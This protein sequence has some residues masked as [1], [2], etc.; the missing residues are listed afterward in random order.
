MIKEKV[1]SIRILPNNKFRLITSLGVEDFHAVHLCIGNLPYKDPYNLIDHPNFIFNPFPME[2]NMDSIP[3]GSRVGVLGTGLTSI[4]IFRY[5]EYNRPDLMLSFFSNSGR[6]K[7]IGGK[8]EHIEYKF[9]TKE[10]IKNRKENNKGFIPLETFINWFKK[11]IENQNLSLEMD[12]I[13]EPFGSK[14]NMEEDLKDLDKI[15]VL[16]SILLDLNPLLTDLWMA[17]TETDK[18][19]FLENYHGQWDKLRSSIPTESGRELILAWEKN[20]IKVFG[21]LTDIIKKENSFEF[22]LKDNNSQHIDYIINAI[23]T[24]KNVSFRMQ[25]IPLIHQLLNE[26]ILQ[27]EAFGGIQVSLP[28]LSTISQKYGI[29]H[30]LKVHGELISGIQFGNNSVD[31]ISETAKDAVE[32]IVQNM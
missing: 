18:Q 26:R 12:L 2:R 1:E 23:G 30:N 25:S 20:K 17:L 29:I 28:E 11:E 4:D 10:N 3:D 22:I 7:S 27:P 19:A 13:N 5:C 8:S 21:K 9:F 14:T 24:E 6:F 16:Q 31:I 15:G 32:D